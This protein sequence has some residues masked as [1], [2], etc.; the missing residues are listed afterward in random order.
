M[1]QPRMSKKSGRQLRGKPNDQSHN[2]SSPQDDAHDSDKQHAP[3]P[4]PALLSR[5]QP[6]NAGETDRKALLPALVPQRLPAVYGK[7]QPAIADA[8]VKGKTGFRTIAH[9]LLIGGCVAGAL[10]FSLGALK[11][12]APEEM[13]ATN[14]I[15]Q[16]DSGAVLAAP[17]SDVKPA[18]EKKT[19]AARATAGKTAATKKTNNARTTSRLADNTK[20]KTATAVA[21]APKKSPEPST[22]LL[23]QNSVAPVGKSIGAQSEYA[24]C[25]EL[26][27]FL[28]RE[29][30]K[31]QVCNGKWGL[32]GC[33]SYA[34]ENR[35]F[36]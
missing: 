31:W 3:H 11:K 26:D 2:A 15:A 17:A 7:P 32:D 25:Q 16:A 18:S 14:R 5:L 24:Q 30:C 29:Q 22:P 6:E 20:K 23:A 19:V 4:V 9:A 28:R 8:A 21:R 10:I 33:P 35:Q 27:S 13:L 34:D 1:A 12:G 36:N